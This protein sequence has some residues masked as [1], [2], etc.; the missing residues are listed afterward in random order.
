M[1]FFVKHLVGVPDCVCVLFNMLV[2]DA[3]LHKREGITKRRADGQGPT[4]ALADLI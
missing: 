2:E 4:I 1:K 3:S